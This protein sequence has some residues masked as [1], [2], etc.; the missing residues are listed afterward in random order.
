MPRTADLGGIEFVLDASALLAFLEGEPGA[1]VVQLVLDRS[2]LSTANWSEVCQ[3]AIARHLDVADLR[4]DVLGL[5]LELSPM[6]ALDAENAAVLWPA[7]R[8]AGLSLGDR[9]C[10]ALTERLGAPALTA[11]RAWLDLSLGIPVRA[12][13]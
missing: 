11:D 4:D 3:R 8:P 13:R 10:L 5:G 7:K 12:I 1:D 9:A 2:A 6:T